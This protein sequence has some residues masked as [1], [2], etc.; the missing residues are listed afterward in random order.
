MRI[1]HVTECFAGGV[2]RAI[3]TAVAL[4]PQHDHHLIFAG[5]DT[6]DQSRFQTISR[7]PRGLLRRVSCV[8]KH[9]LRL[10]PDL[11]H[12]HSSW[13]G[14]YTRTFKL[15]APVVYQPHC[16]K[17][18][19]PFSPSALRSFYRA[20]ETLLSRNTAAVAVLSPHEN[21]LAQK[22]SP[23]TPTYYV[24]NVPSV[25]P[26]R[27]P[28]SDGP[29]RVYM[30][31][32]LSQQKD[33]GHFRDVAIRVR[34]SSDAEFVWI[35]DGDSRARQDLE[36]NG[37][38][39]TGWLDRDGMDEWLTKP[40]IYYHSAGYEGFPLS[41]LDA[42]AFGHPIIARKIDALAD[43]SIPQFS[44]ADA[45]AQALIRLLEGDEEHLTAARRARDEILNSMTEMRQAS[46]LEA[47]Y[48]EVTRGK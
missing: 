28:S 8:R 18:D 30:I 10:R 3:N 17:F 12:A 26:R 23:T 6:P 43:L 45:A 21:R 15:P 25:R 44:N 32:R 9:T 14:V 46:A 40:G 39:V 34:K 37:V 7:L 11:V 5:E 24:P 13:A 19:D 33:P 48:R 20:A 1:V 35:G 27:S 29:A 31:G 47:L 42:A 36:A 22:L 4:A 16:Y 38:T 41:I 2:S